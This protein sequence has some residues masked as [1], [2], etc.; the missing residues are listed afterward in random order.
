MRPA[1][2]TVLFT[3]MCGNTRSGVQPDPILLIAFWR[4]KTQKALSLLRLLGTISPFGSYRF[5]KG[6]EH[7]ALRVIDDN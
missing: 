1:S 5:F 7:P 3:R 6:K 2:V 4:D